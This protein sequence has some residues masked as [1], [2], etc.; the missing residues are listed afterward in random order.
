MVGAL[1][2]GQYVRWVMR[3]RLGQNCGPEHRVLWPHAE[4]DLAAKRVLKRV[5]FTKLDRLPSR[6][7]SGGEGG[8]NLALVTWSWGRMKEDTLS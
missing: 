3:M 4:L 5:A 2:D 6:S 1:G 7:G 8:K